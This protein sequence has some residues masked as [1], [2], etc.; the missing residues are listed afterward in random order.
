VCFLYQKNDNLSEICVH[1][2]IILQADKRSQR[3]LDDLLHKCEEFIFIFIE[4]AKRI[5]MLDV[6]VEF[7]HQ[8]NCENLS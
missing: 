3:D 2:I 7:V 6:R 5:D 8:V 1:K 4:W